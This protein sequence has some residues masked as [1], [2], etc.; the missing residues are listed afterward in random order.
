MEADG[1]YGMDKPINDGEEITLGAQAETV[2]AGAV[3]DAPSRWL[4]LKDASAFLGVHY[5]TVRNWADRGEIRVF[6]TPGG[7]RRF[8]VEDLRA[9]LEERVSQRADH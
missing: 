9:F 7:H 8:S 6:R 4:T 1:E 3:S 5:T 2:N